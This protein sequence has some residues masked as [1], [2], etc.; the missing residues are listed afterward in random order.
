MRVLLKQNNESNVLSIDHSYFSNISNF[1]ML[2][3]HNG[4]QATETIFVYSTT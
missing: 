3:T 4:V 2:L 1:D